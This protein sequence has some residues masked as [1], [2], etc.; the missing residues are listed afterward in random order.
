MVYPG[1]YKPVGTGLFSGNDQLEHRKAL[2]A[3]IYRFVW[4]HLRTIDHC[5]FLHFFFISS[6]RWL[7]SGSLFVKNKTSAQPS[8]R[9]L[10]DGSLI[11]DVA[12]RWKSETIL[13]FALDSLCLQKASSYIYCN[14]LQ[15]L[16]SW[17]TDAPVL[18][19]RLFSTWKQRVPW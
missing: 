7:C 4:I 1:F 12:L 13:P 10:H 8:Y 16:V 2:L 11:S 19:S 9:A 6:M 15:L 14:L 17:Q 3:F 5:P 18:Q